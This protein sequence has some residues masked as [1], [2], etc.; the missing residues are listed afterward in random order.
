MEY[1][2]LDVPFRSGDV[3]CAGWFYRPARGDD[4]PAVVLAHDLVGE[5]SWRLPRVARRLAS[6]GVAAFAFDYRHLG[7]S[8]GKPRRMVASAKQADDLE[9][10]VVEAKA[11]DRVD[12]DRVAV[13]G[14]GLGGGH[15]VEV[16]GRRD[17]AAVVARSPVLDGSAV[18]SNLVK[19][20]GAGY[21]GRAAF[22]VARDLARKYTR[23]SPHEIRVV[24]DPDE[25]ALLNRPGAKRGL[26]SLVPAD[27]AWRNRTPARSLLALR[28]YRP[29][30]AADHVSCPAF[31]VQATDDALF[32][33]DPV[34]DLVDALDDVTR[35]RRDADH[36]D[37]W[38]GGVFDA[39]LDRELAFLD[40]HLGTRAVGGALD[41]SAETRY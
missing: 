6:Q 26:L 4:L 11:F 28:G 20:G 22:A 23:R 8:G 10:A 7:D 37:L 24:G 15:A 3:A 38:R 2:R 27:E 1:S 16:A 17:L 29:L 12:P 9:T 32:P 34:D 39:V 18:V 41:E 30:D 25:F 19:A 21:A 5:R 13:W 14:V 36:F 31:V 35:V 40:D 33:Q